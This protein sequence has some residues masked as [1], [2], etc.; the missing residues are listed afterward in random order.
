MLWWNLRKW[1]KG[2]LAQ[3]EQALR[4]LVHSR[5]ARVLPVLLVTVL[6]RGEWSGSIAEDALVTNFGEKAIDPLLS[7]LIR[8]DQLH[9]D[10]YGFGIQIRASV[11]R[12]VR[13]IGPGAI[14]RTISLLSEKRL[15]VLAS[16]IGETGSAEAVPALLALLATSDGE[17]AAECAWSLRSLQDPS[18]IPGLLA[19]LECGDWRVVNA[20][21]AALVRMKVHQAIGPLSR[22]LQTNCDACRNWD[23]YCRINEKHK[24][25]WHVLKSVC[26]TLLELLPCEPRPI[27]LNALALSLIRFL[28]I[29][30]EEE[31]YAVLFIAIAPPADVV[32]V[33]KRLLDRGKF[34]RNEN[35]KSY[36]GAHKEFW[37]VTERAH[38]AICDT[39]RSITAM[40]GAQ[41]GSGHI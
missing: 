20:A 9:W 6:E 3:K 22:F 31:G 13:R 34:D 16:L 29:V 18:S 36:V 21:A 37:S 32:P 5:N 12:T 7:E 15:P 27:H 10:R 11:A 30:F 26:E 40:R 14:K 4:N 25:G 28:N 24:N 1:R 2:D 19:A 38:C 39:D 8:V 17:T 23:D 41:A 35:I 33:L